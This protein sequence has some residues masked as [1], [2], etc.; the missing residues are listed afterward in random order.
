MEC[1]LVVDEIRFAELPRLEPQRQQHRD[2]RP[3]LPL[4]TVEEVVV[5]V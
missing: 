4:P 3:Y 2:P 1:P 5:R